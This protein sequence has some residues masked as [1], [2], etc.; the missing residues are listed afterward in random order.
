MTTLAA[1]PRGQR[2]GA[3]TLRMLGNETAKGLLIL[4]SHKVTLLPQV[5]MLAVM[6]LLFQLVLGGGHLVTELLPATLFAFLVYVIGYLALLK[7]AVGLLEE[8]NAGT[9]EQIHLSPLR[10]WQLSIGRLGAI[11]IEGVL[12]AILLGGLFALTLGITVPVPLEALVP[13]A[14]TL[15]D[16]AGFAL[17]I[18]GLAL[19]VNS[20]GA[21]VHVLNSMIMMI[22]GSVVPTTAFPP[23]LEIA[24]QLVPTTLGIDATRRVLFEGHGLGELWSDGSLPLTLAHAAVL[25]AAGW[26][27]YQA[28]ISRGL[29]DGRLG[30]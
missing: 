30:P 4:W 24:A 14:L 7:M 23:G 17:L 28:A 25:L 12:T 26:I 10:A 19:V 2:R 9:L 3:A 13:L 22:N 5:T 21:I 15:A 27:T 8:V 18:G 1:P 11:L 6:Y 20:I 16:I 29:R